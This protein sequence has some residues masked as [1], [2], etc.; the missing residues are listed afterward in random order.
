MVSRLLARHA[1][2]ISRRLEMTAHPDFFGT[3]SRVTL[4]HLPVPYQNLEIDCARDTALWLEA[5]VDQ[6]F[7]DLT[8][9]ARVRAGSHSYIAAFQELYVH[10]ASPNLDLCETHLDVCVLHSAQW[11][12][13]RSHSGRQSSRSMYE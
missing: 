10:A 1:S 5:N 3:T 8:Q 6:S 11:P 7:A 12:R 13:A 2:L 4:S 9:E